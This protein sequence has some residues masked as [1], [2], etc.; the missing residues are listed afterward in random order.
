MVQA[1]SVLLQTAH[2]MR[3][4]NTLSRDLICGGYSVN[5]NGRWD[6]RFSWWQSLNMAV[7]CNVAPHVL[8]ETDWCFRGAY[9]IHHKSDGGSKQLLSTG[10]IFFHVTVHIKSMYMISAWVDCILVWNFVIPDVKERLHCKLNTGLPHFVQVIQMSY[11]TDY[12]P[13]ISSYLHG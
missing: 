2:S 11:H 12:V 7:F 13:V 5:K 10:D 3:G 4:L 1:V 8:A 9:C 6:S